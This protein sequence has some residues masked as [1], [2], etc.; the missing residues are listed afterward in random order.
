MSFKNW[1]ENKIPAGQCF[2]Y[3]NNLAREMLDDGIID[4]KDIFICHGMVEKP[5]SLNYHKYTHAWVETK[6][7][8]YDWQMS[9]AKNSLSK[10]DFYELFKPTNVIKYTVEESMKNCLKNKHHGPWN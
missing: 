8:V 6:D 3:A 9:L 2:S 5:Y 4:E 1:L 7:R 10:E